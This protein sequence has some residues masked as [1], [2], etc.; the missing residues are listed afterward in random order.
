MLGAYALRVQLSFATR[1]LAALGSEGIYTDAFL[2]A[3]DGTMPSLSTLISGLP[4]VGVH[5]NYQPAAKQPFPTA[6]APIFKRLGYRTRFFYSGYLSWQR[7]G[8]FCREQGF[9]EVLW[10]IGNERATHWQRMGC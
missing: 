5:V 9:D 10:W 1:R 2:S 7:L 4:E 8:D 6:T 3:G